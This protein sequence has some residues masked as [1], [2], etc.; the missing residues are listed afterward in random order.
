MENYSVVRNCNVPCCHGKHYIKFND[1][2]LA[3]VLVGELFEIERCWEKNIENICGKVCKSNNLCLAH[4]RLKIFKYFMEEIRETNLNRN[5]V[6]TIICIKDN[7][8]HPYCM[9]S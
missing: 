7:C 3:S 1:I 2:G 9:N 6:A 4:K 5:I 8:K